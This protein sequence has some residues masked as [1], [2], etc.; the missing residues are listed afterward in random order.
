MHVIILAGG[1]GERL[2]PLTAD[3]PKAMVEIL[4]VPLLGYQVRWL[5]TQGITDIIVACGYRHEVIEDYFGAGE[6][7]GVRVQYAVESQPLGRGGALK[8]AFRFLKAGEDMCLATN[9]DV[10]TNVRLA[11]LLQAHRNSGC[12]ATIMLVPFTSPYGIVDVDPSEKIVAFRE[13]PE[14]PYWLN[15]GIYVFSREI[16]PLLPDQGDHEDTTFPR[17]AAERKLGAFKSRSF[18]RTVDTAKDLSEIH[19][20]LERQPLTSFLA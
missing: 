15:A 20:E 3:R 9:G 17:L 8:L 14:L 2:R 11:P 12:V 19:K 10:V 1:K 18:W 16:E 6:K 13:K 7:W 4:G 5:Q